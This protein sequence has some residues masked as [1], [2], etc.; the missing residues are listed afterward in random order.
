MPIVPEKMTTNITNVTEKITA[1]TEK[2]DKFIGSSCVE[3]L[4][5][6]F[7]FWPKHFAVS[8]IRK[9]CSTITLQF[10]KIV[11]IF[12]QASSFYMLATQC[13][14]FVNWNCHC[15]WNQNCVNEHLQ[16]FFKSP[17]KNLSGFFSNKK[18]AKTVGGS[19]SMYRTIPKSLR[20]VL[21]AWVR[22][23]LLA[24]VKILADSHIYCIAILWPV[25]GFQVF[26]RPFLRDLLVRFFGVPERLPPLEG[27][28][29]REWG[30]G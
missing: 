15:I 3:A 16:F 6:K 26:F 9:T 28:P 8:I 12:S 10:E 21:L 18:K 24:W 25:Y 30:F 11:T 7:D 5:Q 29:R 13:L 19:C 4:A 20:E 27:V 22:E 1:V 2:L 17:T 14:R 23:V